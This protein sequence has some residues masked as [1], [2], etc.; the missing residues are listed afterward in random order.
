AV[1]SVAASHLLS[2]RAVGTTESLMR[3]VA[4]SWPYGRFS[5][6]ERRR[7][8]AA[9]ATSGAGR[10][11][12]GWPVTTQSAAAALACPVLRHE[13]ACPDNRWASGACTPSRR[14]ARCI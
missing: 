11:A 4:G 7:A 10:E 12:C 3:G 2:E 8:L 6:S 5:L 1:A 9:G 13:G 14:S